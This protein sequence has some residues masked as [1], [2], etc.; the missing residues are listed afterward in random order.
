M[1][2]FLDV[3]GFELRLQCRSP[4]FVGLCL[5]FFAIHLLT[6]AQ[7]GINIVDNE[8]IDYNSPSVIFRIEA[9]LNVFGLLPALIFVV[10]AATRD[11]A[12]I[13]T[14]FFYVTPVDRLGFLLGRLAGGTVCALLVALA[15][16]LGMYA[17]TFMPWLTP[18][19]IAAFAWQPYVASYLLLVVP[20]LL[21]FSVFSFAVATFTRSAALSFAVALVMVVF[22][23]FFNGLVSVDSPD[24]LS[25]FDPF[26]ALALQRA[27]RYWSLAE[28]N[29]LQPLAFLPANR[30]LWLSLAA[31]VL[32]LT[33]WRFR[34]QLAAAGPQWFSKW[35]NRRFKQRS[36]KPQAVPTLSAQT[37][38][39]SFGGRATFAQFVSQWRMD[40]RAVL[41]SPLFWLVVVL[42]IVSTFSEISN[43]KSAVMKLPNHPMTS[44]MLTVMRI[45]LLQFV[46]LVLVFYSALLMHREREHN[47]HEL[48]GAAPYPDWLPLM[49]KVLTICAVLMLLQAC[50]ML[51]SIAWQALHGYYDFE[52]GVYL[53][54]LLVNNGFYFCM[55]GVLACVLQLLVPGKWSGMV[56]VV[57]ALV[58]LLTLPLT[59]FDHLLYGFRIPFVQYTDMNGWGQFLQPVYT[60]I[61][62]WSMFCVL[63]LVAGHLLIPR[64]A[65][66]GIGARLR[67]AGSRFTPAVRIT[68][69]AAAAVF[70]ALGGWI[71]YNTNVLNDYQ[72]KDSRARQQGEYERKYAAWKQQPTP[73][74]T[75]IE[76]AFDLYPAERRMS[77]SGR[78]TLRNDQPAALTEVFITA[79]V[80]LVIDKL[81]VEGGTLTMEDRKQSVFLFTLSRPLQP[82]AE[83]S[84]TWTATRA[85][86]GFLGNSLPDG[87]IVGNGTFIHAMSV[88]PVP[89]YVILRELTD[90]ADRKRMHLPPVPRLPALGDPAWL[91][92]LDNGIENRPEFSVVFST[93][94]D[95][96]AVAP[97][98]LQREWEQ[99]G[100]HYFQYRMETPTRPALPLVSARYEVARDH[101]NDVTIE[102]YYDAKH[103]WNVGTMMH[104]VKSAMQYFS[105][106]FAPYPLEFFRIAEYPGYE[107]HA[108]AHAGMITYTET[109]GFM[110]DL[111]GWAPL[112]YATIHEL[113]HQW[114]GGLAYGAR[115]QGRK[116]LNEGLA[117]YSS[118]MLLK[119]E[120]NQQWVRQVVSKVSGLYMNGRKAENVGEL[121]VLL[122]EDQPYL[123]YAKSALVLFALQE[124]IGAD[125]VNLALRRYL[126]RFALKGPP[127][128]MSRDLV[129]ELRKVA[130][131]E[132]QNFITDQWEK[133]MLYD[134]Q[135]TGAT[136]AQVGNEYEV[137][138]D[139]NARQF[140]SDAVGNETEV[141]LDTW[142]QVVVF[143][144]SDQ[145]RMAQTPLYQAEHRLRG[146]SQRITVRVPQKPGAAGV[147]PYH[148]MIDRSPQNNVRQ[149]AH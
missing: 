54:V 123:T 119:Q 127:F 8:L 88:V 133:I 19:R 57:V 77:A 31:L 26:G 115:M 84:M 76:L 145:E 129:D 64:G 142:F 13:T 42:T 14:E 111:S 78:V 4:L 137:S 122:A 73:T 85:N 86:R 132:Y 70:V 36:G 12:L 74:V 93:D 149:L 144:D 17:G 23:L 81:V 33:C 55:L 116:I 131:P 62:Y 136:V 50:S 139:I 40:L 9:M 34:L 59:R 11:Q 83:T 90:N 109:V 94:A 100:R 27:G 124:L 71:F 92:T 147:D 89:F 52:L 140:E 103:P 25:M 146:G 49:S 58:G 44:Q 141:P 10:S 68:A 95:Q 67:E 120:A 65:Y 29:R 80:G 16:S 22:A 47:L 66:S 143:P 82:G 30:A 39:C 102:I 75:A 97:G 46:L 113:S 41:L 108:Q 51:A 28:L 125:K 148:L 121:P 15:G 110:V 118:W 2:N 126:D 138:M 107:D 106:E 60:L 98:T 7:A 96:I 1:R 61:A 134:V 128:P 117:E 79:P 5:L 53:Q 3:L 32:T 63:L 112:D 72:S 114:W 130:G 99:A 6:M 24:W 37:W 45:S 48:I 38:Q 56:L 20:N 43:S 101:W 35:F 91:G 87:D 18:E 104:T 135:M 69:M 105:R 21:V